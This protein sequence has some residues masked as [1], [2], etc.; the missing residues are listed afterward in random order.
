MQ[1][2]DARI[3]STSFRPRSEPVDTLVLHYTALDRD[4]SLR[5]LRTGAVSAHYVLDMDG[6]AYRILENHEVAFHAGLS[7]WRGR[8]RV[9]ERSIGVE[10]V[11]RDGN[12][13]PYPA[14]QIEALIALCRR[15]VGEN[16]RIE[17]ANVVGH[18]DVAPKRKVDP[19]RLFPWRTLAEAGI[20]RWPFDAAPEPVGTPAAIQALLEKCGYPAPH[21]YGTR[22]QTLVFV[23]DPGRPP[24]GV[25]NVVRVETAD[26]LRA[27]MLR[28]RPE[29]ADGP[30]DPT[31]MGRLRRLAAVA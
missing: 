7:R 13:H 12:Q 26:I 1:I 8:P 5:V 6:T 10:I 24:P 21:A 25:T 30:P 22:G 19:G 9:N 23:A 3:Q 15:I 29:R 17:P 14:A 28:F 20:G 18:S 11:N 4:A 2:I 27:F 31:A 16:P